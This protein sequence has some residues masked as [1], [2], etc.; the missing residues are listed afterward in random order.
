LALDDETLRERLAQVFARQDFYEACKRRDA[1][2]MVRILMSHGITQGQ[3][4]TLT[5]IAQSTLSNYKRGI[6]QAEYASTFK[7]FADGLGMPMPLRQALGLSADN[8]RGRPAHGSADLASGM[9]ADTFDLI[10]LA[11]AAGRN[12]GSVKRRELLSMAATLGASAAVTHSEAWER[13]AYA[14]TNPSALSESVVKEVEARTVGFHLVEP[15]VPDLSLLKAL[16]VQLNEISTLL[17]GTAIDRKDPLRNRL[18]IAAGESAVL[19]GWSASNAGDSGAARNWY[20]TA[21]KAAMEAGD[22]AIAACALAYRSYIPSTKGANGRARALLAEALQILSGSNAD[23]AS[24]GSIAWI[25]AMHAVESAQ[26]GD[27][28]QALTS[29][30]RAEQAYSV[31]D[32]EDDRIWTF[33]LDRNRFDSYQIAAYSRIGRIDEAQEIAAN[34]I[35]RLGQQDRG[36]KKAV[37]ISEDIARAHLTRGAITEAAKVAKT[38]VITLREI[39]FAMWLPKYEEIAQALRPHS[40][41]P[42]VRAYL[43]EFAATK[44]QV[45]SQ[46]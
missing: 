16:T 9:P 23:T 37:I 5:G 22:P 2:S 11:E 7:T 27:T 44:R 21:Q 13:L 33:F 14:L 28:R 45:L 18:L 10:R 35:A 20:D 12:G 30:K 19:A 29:W 17:G 42:A 26:L 15:M 24:P 8:S 32:P 38:G 1:G 46:R 34:V 43:E 25:S 40:R 39:G 31:A 41:Q 36:R 4:S 6:H 3:L